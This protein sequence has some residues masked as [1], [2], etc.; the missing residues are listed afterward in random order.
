MGLDLIESSEAPSAAGSRRREV[1]NIL[2]WLMTA[3]VLV[4][5]VFA[6]GL[7]AGDQLQP[8]P[9]GKS[10]TVCPARKAEF[11]TPTTEPFSRATDRG[12]G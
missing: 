6:V 3:V 5:V 4:A 11:A 9:A 10:G 7:A 2:A 1:R 8:I 12:C